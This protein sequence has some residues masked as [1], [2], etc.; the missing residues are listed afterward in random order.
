[1]NKTTGILLITL[2]FA[3]TACGQKEI[4]IA[5]FEAG[6]VQ[7]VTKAKDIKWRPC[8]PT[9]PKGC[10]MTVLSGHPKKPDMFTVRFRSKSKIF[11]PAHT[12]PKDER[13]TIL[14]GK[15]AVAFGKDA[16]R[17][18]AK[19]FGAGDHYINKRN[20]IHKVWLEEGNILQITGIGPWEAHFIDKH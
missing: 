19:E 2:S 1:M 6:Q 18:E 10:E 20:E 15:A 9:L 17:A 5:K 14:E 11:M 4:G 12:H 3:V 7:K 8:P 16:T 13:V